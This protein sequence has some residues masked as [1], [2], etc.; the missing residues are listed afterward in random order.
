MAKQGIHGRG[1]KKK[2][3]YGWWQLGQ[4]MKEDIETLLR[5]AEM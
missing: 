3:V 4:V 1:M 5:C 2:D